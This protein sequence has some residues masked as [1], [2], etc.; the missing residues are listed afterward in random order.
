MTREGI[1]IFIIGAYEIIAID[2]TIRITFILLIIINLAPLLRKERTLSSVI[3]WYLHSIG[4][5]YF[6]VFT[7]CSFKAQRQVIK[8]L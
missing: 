3:M 8:N 1:I 5:P 4:V 2:P 6:S 7:I